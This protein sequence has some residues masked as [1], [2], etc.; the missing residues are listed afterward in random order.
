M[1][2]LGAPAERTRKLTPRAPDQSWGLARQGFVQNVYSDRMLTEAGAL[3]IGEFARRVGVSPEL[4]RAWERRYNLLEPIRSN[5]GFRLYTPEDAERVARM[6]RG[7]A[8]GLS[9]AEA[10]R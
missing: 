6:Q 3:R 9:A 10:A 4:L 5:G 1:Q 7:L 8:E 2:C